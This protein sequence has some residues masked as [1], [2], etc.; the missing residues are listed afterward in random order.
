[1]HLKT[2]Q[3][4]YNNLFFPLEIFIS[5]VLTSLHSSKFHLYLESFFMKW[6]QTCY[7]GTCLMSRN[8]LIGSKIQTVLC[9]NPTFSLETLK[10]LFLQFLPT[11]FFFSKYYFLILNVNLIILSM[12][13]SDFIIQFLWKLTNA[14]VLKTV[15]ILVCLPNISQVE[16]HGNYN[17]ILHLTSYNRVF[18]LYLAVSDAQ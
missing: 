9:F 8:G 3:A 16:E 2:F 6:L 15:H 1:M 11:V 14:L 18:K 10:W 7:Y 13:F 12:F 5:L 4:F 17:D